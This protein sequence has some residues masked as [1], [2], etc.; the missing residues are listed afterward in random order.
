MSTYKISLT[1]DASVLATLRDEW[2]ALQERSHTQGIYMSW[3]WVNVWW[4][5]FGKDY[6][7]WLM[8]AHT[9]DGKLVGIAPFT[10][11]YYSA[12]PKKLGIIKWKQ[13]Q[14]VGDNMGGQHVDLLIEQ[15]H[16]Q[17]VTE[18]FIQHLRGFQSKWDVLH[19]FG[20]CQDTVGNNVIKNNTAIP[21]E[22]QENIVAPYIALP[23]SWD[24]YF[25][26][27]SKLKRKAERRRMRDLDEQFGDRWSFERVTTVEMFNP[28]FERM[29][30]LHQALWKERGMPGAFHDARF[31]AFFKEWSIRFL[32]RGWLRMYR[33][34]LDGKLAAVLCTYEYRGRVYDF[35]SG[36]DYTYGD[37]GV[38][39]VVT[40]LAL[41]AAIEGGIHEYDFMWGN[42]PYKYD[43]NA[44][45]RFHHSYTWYASWQS[46]LQKQFLESA[47]N[48]KKYLKKYR[49]I[50]AM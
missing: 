21:W 7:L 20:L 28:T 38:G 16:E 13:M 1:H 33:L 17:A 11:G 39:H 49:S 25:N 43:W 8:Q 27:L 36:V 40:Q 50:A 18:A 10:L 19:F 26:G 29:V 45:D 30:E 5:Y 15:G 32:K 24:D 48:M 42:E 23:E 3:E 31:T 9:T 46:Q 22:T 12:V 35:V 47:R 4:D 34:C 6:E 14:L 41:K 2:E 37:L 44:V